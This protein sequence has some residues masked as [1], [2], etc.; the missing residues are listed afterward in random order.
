MWKLPTKSNRRRS[1]LQC[2]QSRQKRIWCS[3]FEFL[4]YS[5]VMASPNAYSYPRL[6]KDPLLKQTLP[7]PPFHSPSSVSLEPNCLRE[8]EQREK[9]ERELKFSRGDAPSQPQSRS[10]SCSP[11]LC[12]DVNRFK[13]KYPQASNR[14][15][16]GAPNRGGSEPLSSPPVWGLH[17]GPLAVPDESA[18]WGRIS[19]TQKLNRKMDSTL[20]VYVHLCV[21]E[22]ERECNGVESERVKVEVTA[23]PILSSLTCLLLYLCLSRWHLSSLLMEN[24]AALLSLLCPVE[25]AALPPQCILYQSGIWVILI[26]RLLAI[27]FRK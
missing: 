17:T 5:K 19:T 22:W 13:G 24:S 27:P 9:E 2:V 6:L 1:V 11:L 20:H 12:C 18:A 4:L 26:S 23:V 21:L 15:A 25:L 8:K 14:E 10:K 16:P 7:S 3:S